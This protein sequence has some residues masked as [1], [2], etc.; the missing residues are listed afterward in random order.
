MRKLRIN[1]KNKK[2]FQKFAAG[3]MAAVITVSG[4]TIPSV[5]SEAAD[6]EYEIYP[7]PQVIQYADGDYVIKNEVNVVYESGIDQE[8]KDRLAEALALKD[9]VTV[10][11]S[12]SI[13]EGKTN[14][15]VG[16][17]GSGEVADTYANEHVNM[18]SAD[19]YEKLD[20]YVL[21]SNNDV[22][23]VVGADTDASY[24]GLTTLYHI[25]K[26]M[27]SNTIRNFHIEDWADVASRGFIEGYYG[28]PWSTEDRINLMKWGGYYK[29]NSY[30]YAPKND[31]K[32]NA[33]WR[34]LYTEEELNTLIRP[35]AEAGN[36]SKCRFVYAL[37]T[38]MHNPV[39]FDSNYQADLKAVQDK[40]AQVI[41]AGV[42]QV[43]I[44]ADDAGNV[45]GDNYNK[46]LTDMTA[47]LAEMKKT[48]PDL[49]QTLPFCPQ[50]YMYN[51]QEYY[52]NF[53]ENVQIVMTGGK[54]WGEVNQNFT[55]TFTNN[56]GRG[57]YMWINWPC[58][59][60]S[61][62][63]LIMGGY[64]TF[65]HPG[66][67]PAKIQGIVL[68][69]M[70]QSE[71]SKVAIF[72]N[73][74]YSWNIWE[75][76]DIANKA[77]EDS[78][79]YVDHN[80][81]VETEASTALYELSKHMMNQN[82]DNRVTALQESVELAPKLTA[83]RDKLKTGTV[84]VKEADA[85]IAEFQILQNAA[86]IYREQAV[87]TKVRDQIVYWLDCWDD[88]TV[89]A[90]G[91]LNAIKAIINEEADTAL[92]YNAE[93]K[94]AFEQ[95]KTH[96]LWYLDHYEKAE[97]GVQ[98]I[99]P[100]IKAMAKYVTDYID[101]GIN[102]NTQERYT[103]TVTYNQ[104]SIQNNTPEDRYF[105]R[106]DS[107]EVWLARGPYEGSGRDTIPAG[108]TLTVTFPEPKTIGSFRLVQGVS[109]TG[110]KFSNADVEYQIE[111][112]NTWTKAGTLSNKGDQTVSFG[113]VANVKAVRIHNK[114]VTGGW[115]RI[116]EIEILSPANEDA[117]PIEY[118]II[119]TNRWTVADSEHVE[120]KLHDGDDNSYV[121]YDPDGSGN[122]TNDT[123]KENDYL[124]YDLGKVA[125]LVSA[126]IV[127]G[128]DNTDKMKRYKI[129]TS[130]D[131][132]KWT[133]VDGYDN[134]TGV[135]SGKDILNIDLT[136]T[137]ARYIRICNLEDYQKWV[138]F[139]EFTVKEKASGAR[140][141]LY[142]NVDTNITASLEEGSVS[143]SNGTVTLNK[144]EYIGVK[145]GD[146]KAIQNITVPE[147]PGNV[148]LETSMN[149]ITWQPYVA[150]AKNVD[151][152]YIRIRNNGEEA[153]EIILND[154]AVTYKFV[155]AKKVD[156]NFEK[157]QNENDM[158]VAGT[159]GNV[160]DGKLSTL[161]MINGKQEAGKHITFDLGQVIHFNSLRYYIVETQLNYLRN[162]KFEVSTD[163]T[164]WTE[165][166]TVGKPTQNVHDSTVAKDMQG[167]TL[168]HD[169]KNPGYMYKEAK[170]LDVDGRYIRI[171]PNETY[172]HRW[173]A[174]NELQINGGEYISSEQSRQ[175]VSE[176]IEEAGKIPSNMRDGSYGT[177]YKSS[178]KNSSFTWRVLDPTSIASV[179]LIQIGDI[180]KADVTATY[181]DKSN[182]TKAS[183][184]VKLGKLNQVINEFVIPEGKMLETL[185]VTWK[186]VIP[187]IAEIE[188]SSE[189]GGEVNKDALKTELEKT[190]DETWTADSKTAYAQAKEVAQEI[191]D[192]KNASQAMVESAI[193][194]LE[195]ARTNAKIK[196]DVETIQKIKRV[197]AGKI[198]N[199]EIVYTKVTYTAY[200]SAVNKL[201]K[202]MKAPDNLSQTDADSLMK[203]VTE[204]QNNLVY[205]TRN[206]E[207]AELEA[208]KYAL[209][210]AEQYTKASYQALS[211]IKSEID[212]LTA[213][214][215][216]A[217][218]NGAER[219]NPKEFIAKRTAF[220][221][222]MNN[223]V[224]ITALK[225]AI[226]QSENVDSALYTKES[227]DSYIAAV[228][229]GKQLLNAGTK[230]QVAE[231]LKLIEE[232]YN[233]LVA[234]ENATLEK[235][236][237]AAKALKAES[238]TEDSYQA[239]MDIVAEAEKSG[240]NK[241]IDKIQEAMKK[242]VNVEALKEKI[243]AAENV[244]K[245]LYTEDSY[246]RLEN[247][248]KKTK[249]LL[250]SGSEKEVKAATEELENARRALVRK[251][252]V[253]VEGNQ[254]NA[255]Q[256][257]DQKG[258][259]VQT[260]DEGNLLPIVLVMVAC[261][262]IIAV[263][264]IRRKR[265]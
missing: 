197:L 230:E 226:K 219:V 130:L 176:A 82:M 157:A 192:N 196:A 106:D 27:D 35:L 72:G 163:G 170:G 195:S 91:Y 90:I 208:E 80:S 99:V 84:T 94:A 19:L 181:L 119:R 191:Y 172:N 86:A 146:I 212:T 56:A 214:D 140:A 213:K 66:V 206:R 164:N 22:I 156:T 185:T 210:T 108:A 131:G 198:S 151:A 51:G 158:R 57:P 65:L 121:W 246:Q 12:E 153:K 203:N 178:K 211:A 111:G 249:K 102:P 253:D 127:I 264:I 194:T 143:L 225:A 175:I 134:Y 15:L 44:L 32:H 190:E 28:N 109:A 165:V 166:M 18:Q 144:D 193:K 137:R 256:N 85:L 262:V 40:L 42:R 201:E 241:Y 217:E 4:L 93:A 71:P 103:G 251:T 129:E 87:D 160:F 235:V 110:D 248:L 88:T 154:F 228:E 150:D 48:Y 77:W 73:A 98:H 89:S 220:Q 97:V 216:E 139:S 54:V 135:E 244:D 207:L 115:V 20:A 118:N 67:D 159:V 75:N 202:A 50:E 101:T 255:G 11:T 171:M 64:T 173:V 33:K 31:P 47:W 187:E 209:V 76:A 183:K 55:N 113:T 261:I 46:F 240:D 68:N 61:K 63:H 136:G 252:T 126:H 105:D 7:N 188:T 231:A 14:I 30:F 232:K 49:K 229:A 184:E 147:L 132:D 254:N 60:N 247:A 180:S 237:Q 215:K 58:T 205:S 161:G 122:T 141:G 70:Q 5:R 218:T 2:S 6:V 223:L 104:I 36:A 224:D 117:R 16:I 260:G 78:F 257:T 245:K 81:A 133:A 265:K 258:Q 3:F 238:Y 37:H 124:G 114:T 138:K 21:D 38:F 167:I 128:A 242:L 1:G 149:E 204:A 100:F 182:V 17:D 148:V 45:G 107:S 26:Q 83:F 168:T 112:T 263:V 92:R 155:G 142:T 95:S 25:L 123:C 177:T 233:G 59:D 189:R 53:P 43:A 29:L 10:T 169:D 200:V 236:I 62:N 227:Y 39:R 125:D 8:T 222:A 79:K 24:Y 116:G 52:K 120:S 179:R 13:E 69:P 199:D 9:G 23:T 96:E 250:K 34:E 145:L 243:Q 174:I 162:A 41:E 74:C 234:N 259:A 221:T 239:L 186:D 152:A